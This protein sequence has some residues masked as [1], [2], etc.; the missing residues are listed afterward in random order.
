MEY[1]FNIDPP[2]AG[3]STV[4]RVHSIIM[5]RALLCISLTQA[6]ALI[7]KNFPGYGGINAR[8]LGNFMRAA[9]VHFRES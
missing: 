6:K 9:T 1:D 8:D 7:D 3:S 2:T 5:L 4:C